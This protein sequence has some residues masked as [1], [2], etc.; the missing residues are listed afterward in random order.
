MCIYI[1]VLHVH[2]RAVRWVMLSK[3]SFECIIRYVP[4]ALDDKLPS[5]SYIK[6]SA[7]SGKILS[8]EALVFL[9]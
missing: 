8:V 5:A 3:I 1:P 6:I 2:T 9:V 4:Y 7:I